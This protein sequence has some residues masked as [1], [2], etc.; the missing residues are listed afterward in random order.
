MYAFTCLHTIMIR[1]E[2]DSRSDHLKKRKVATPRIIKADWFTTFPW[3]VHEDGMFKCKICVNTK[4]S[5]VFATSKDASRPKKDDLT[6]HHN[7]ADHRRSV[8]LPKRQ[9]EFVMASITTN[10]HAKAGIVTRLRTV[11]TQAK[12][13]IPK[14]K[15][16][17]LVELHVLN[18]SNLFW[19][20][21]FYKFKIFNLLRAQERLNVT[22][23]V[24]SNHSKV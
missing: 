18:V 9:R 15:N 16:A 10:D 22:F 21:F 20:C 1:K 13:C 19:V 5:N 17:P 3:L 2:N 7:S 4:A 6:K 24:S 12:H 8:A 14:A 23:E 11:L